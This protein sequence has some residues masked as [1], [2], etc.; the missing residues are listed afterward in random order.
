MS[1]TKIHIEILDKAAVDS[2]KGLLDH[3]E[4]QFNPA[5]FTL[6]KGAQIAEIG[7]PGI[8]SPILQFIRGQDERLTL[9]LLFDTTD[10]GMGEDAVDVTTLTRQVYQLVKIQPETH[11]P[12]RFKVTWGKALAFTAIAEQ[13]QQK[14]TLFSPN[15]TP[16]RANVS[17]TLRE[18]KTL[19]EQLKE[20]KL[21]S[22]DH[23]KV[24]V[25][26]RGDTLSD[27]AAAEYGDPTAWRQL[28]DYNHVP[29]PR[30]PRPGSTLRIPPLP[31]T[32]GA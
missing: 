19:D 27:I 30:R 22:P 6:T 7:I 10:D 15:G 16:L 1:L 29:D 13:V 18:H 14:F 20:L 26:R 11:A 12:P 21:A 31:L 32:G 2:A 8:D 23:T 24:W 9:D 28:A 25:V 5:E 17:L 4:V 3:F